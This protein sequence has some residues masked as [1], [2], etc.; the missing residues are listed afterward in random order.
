MSPEQQEELR[1][2]VRANPAC[3]AALATKDCAAIASL[4][5]AGR[6]R[7]SDVEV[8]N[9]TI[10]EVIGIES[11]NRLLDTINSDPNMRYVKPLLE[12]GRLKVGSPVAQAAIQGFATAGVIEQAD[13]DNLCALGQMSDPLTAQEVAEA[14]FNPDGSEK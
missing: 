1:A 3:A 12:Q 14:L 4:M 7:A 6:T 10:L 11:G 13:A 2:A 5:S 8:G 9:G